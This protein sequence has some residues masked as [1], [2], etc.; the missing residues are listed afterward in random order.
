MGAIVLLFLPLAGLLED[1]PR[2]A[3]AATVIVAV[4]K[5]ID[6][7]GLWRTIRT[8][9]IDGCVALGTVAV[10]LT[11]EP[12]IHYAVVIAIVAA[13]IIGWARRHL[14]LTRRD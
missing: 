8:D 9:W 14:A 12:R 7:P 5:L 1:L 10:T 11:M 2:A 3:L 4:Y 6:I 13:T